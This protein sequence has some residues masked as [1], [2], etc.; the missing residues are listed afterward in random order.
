MAT[1]TIVSESNTPNEG[2]IAYNQN[3][4]NLND[5]LADVIHADGSVPMASTLDMGSNRG[6]NASAGIDPTDFVILSQLQDEVNK[7]KGS[8]V[9][10]VSPNFPVEDTT[11]GRFQTV[12]KALDS[13]TDGT[14]GNWY[15]I[16]VHHHPDIENGGYSEDLQTYMKNYVNI[17]GVG[18]PVVT[19]TQ[20]GAEDAEITGNGFIEGIRFKFTGHSISESHLKFSGLTIN[21]NWFKLGSISNSADMILSTV[22]MEN[23]KVAVSS[24]STISLDGTTNN[25]I[26][27]NTFSTELVLGSGMNFGVSNYEVPNIVDFFNY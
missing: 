25:F 20:D 21:N 13:I 27:G 26:Q 4:T 19:I 16:K 8:N 10:E 1:I 12:Y 2:R 7:F 18:N 23:N 22:A 5:E 9:L 17:I 24:V 14:T 11:A 15:F 3:D 6:V